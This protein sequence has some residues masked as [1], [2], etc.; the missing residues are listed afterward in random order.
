MQG[1]VSFEIARFRGDELRAEAA[2]LR[3]VRTS[4]RSRRRSTRRR[5]ARAL[6][7][8]G[9]FFVDIGRNIGRGEEVSDGSCVAH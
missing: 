8:F 1:F 6:L 7:A 5:I 3:L 4:L 9:F 2:R